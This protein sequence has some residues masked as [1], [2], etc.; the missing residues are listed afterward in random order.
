MPDQPVTLIAG[1]TASGLDD[2]AMFLTEVG[3][4]RASIEVLEAGDDR[5]AF[6]RD[7]DRRL[8]RRQT[9]LTVYLVPAEANWDAG[10]IAD[11]EGRVKRLQ[12]GER[13]VTV[14]FLADPIRLWT[15]L[16]TPAPMASNSIGWM[17][18]LP[19]HES[20][21]AQWLQ[22]RQLSG[23]KPM[24]E[25][26]YAATGYWP[27]ELVSLVSRSQSESDLT[28]RCEAAHAALGDPASEPSTRVGRALGLDT[29]AH[30]ESLRKLARYGDALTY[31]ELANLAAVS[32][33]E[34]AKALRWGD[35]LGLLRR[36][37][38]N[39][40]MVDPVVAGLLRAQSNA[41]PP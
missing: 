3:H 38:E 37:G 19:W 5:G 35:L 34:A 24:L 11:A 33:E 8:K 9:G 31:E 16:D 20:F 13:A 29:G 26:L 18:L 28:R 30:V 23:D 22:G 12:A 21:V 15:T 27:S 1:T 7:L 36:E 4:G 40:W 14:L 32:P 25:R 17:T 10:W 39:A 2:L 41:S 6:A